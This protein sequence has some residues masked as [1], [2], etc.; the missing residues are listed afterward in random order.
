MCLARPLIGGEVLHLS[1][2]AFLGIHSSHCGMARE[3]GT[4]DRGQ[5]KS[6]YG[7]V[8]RFLRIVSGG[9]EPGPT[10]GVTEALAGE[11]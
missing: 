6:F 4:S 1:Q 5:S 10:D 8:G 7:V 2:Q 9:R 3:V 11:R